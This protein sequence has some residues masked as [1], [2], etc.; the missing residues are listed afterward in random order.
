MRNKKAAEGGV[1]LGSYVL[2]ILQLESFLSRVSRS[3]T[4]SKVNHRIVRRE[5]G[6]ARIVALPVELSAMCTLK[7]HRSTWRRLGRVQF[8]PGR[9]GGNFGRRVEAIVGART[10][11]GPVGPFPVVIAENAGFTVARILAKDK[12]AEAGIPDVVVIA[13]GGHGGEEDFRDPGHAEVVA[14]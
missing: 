3:M 13:V 9:C 4:L 8:H 10:R 12:R 2:D 7:R 1:V 14:H 5:V 11:H 6:A